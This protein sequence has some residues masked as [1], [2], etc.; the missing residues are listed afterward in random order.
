LGYA[1]NRTTNRFLLIDNG[2]DTD[3]FQP[4]AMDHSAVRSE[5]GLDADEFVIAVAAR[6]DPMKDYPTLLAAVGGIPTARVVVMGA[7]VREALP[8]S[9]QFVSL[10]RRDDVP[11]VLR[12]ADV[13]ASS[14]AYG[15]GFSNAIAEALATGLPVVATD[16]GDARRIVGDAGRI[17]APRD[18]EALAAALRAVMDM[19]DRVALGVAA[20]KRM[21][22]LFSLDRAIEKFDILHRHGPDAP[23]LD[24]ALNTVADGS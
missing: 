7:G 5:L 4:D 23:A 19:P 20:R 14:S 11:R 16:V 2:V 8:D 13:L 21:V 9:P 12:A 6:Y 10:G 22:A 17:V 1:P 24:P 18:P 3:R 15:E